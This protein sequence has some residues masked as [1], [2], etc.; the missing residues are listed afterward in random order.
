MTG[1]PQK[2]KR[3]TLALDAYIAVRDLLLDGKRYAP[4]AKIS[5]EELAGAL[6]V[7]RS[8]VWSA[9]A[10]LEAEG[11]VEVTPRQGVFL[12]AFDPAR[13]TALFEAREALE[14]MAARLAARKMSATELA[15]L[16][17]AIGRQSAAI[18]EQ[19]R[20]A[21]D[22]ANLLFHHGLLDGAQS[23]TIKKSLMALYAQ[24]RAMC[25]KRA[26]DFAELAANRDE[27]EAILRALNAR[28]EEQAERTARHHVAELLKKLLKS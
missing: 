3:S 1:A 16:A 22:V 6:G 9:V 25:G 24:T 17:E 10:R 14:G 2:L 11:I 28:D 18:H 12:I 21:Y 23:P 26:T 7:S 4:G 5:I 20:A 13:L 8:P 27:H 19:N 15:V